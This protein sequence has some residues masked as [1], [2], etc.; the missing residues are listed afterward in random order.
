VCQKKNH[1]QI[2]THTTLKQEP[3]YCRVNGIFY[4]IEK[5]QLQI[6][7]MK[8][9]S[10]LQKIEIKQSDTDRKQ[11]DY[12]PIGV[13][14][15]PNKTIRTTK[16]RLHFSHTTSNNNRKKNQPNPDQRYF[17][18]VVEMQIVLK[19]NPIDKP[20]ILCSSVSEKV[21][22]R[23]VNP[24]QFKNQEATPNNNNNNNN[25][26]SNSNITSPNVSLNFDVMSVKEALINENSNLSGSTASVNSSITQLA[27]KVV[28]KNVALMGNMG[29]QT[30][31]L[32][33]AL[34]VNGNFLN[35][36]SN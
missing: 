33:E 23:A 15:K 32:D 19:D 21:I 20:L 36:F 8:M 28:D 3:T 9:E 18:L 31:N 7:G 34:N 1:F 10:H 5:I 22:V 14:F 12:E 16:I 6:Y 35:K 24:G 11:F 13:R 17:L 25:S 30:Q 29:I 26:N 27:L 4:S 2:T